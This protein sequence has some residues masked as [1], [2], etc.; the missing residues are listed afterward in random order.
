MLFHSSNII[1]TG[2]L[3][4]AIVFTG[5]CNIVY[6]FKTKFTRDIIVQEKY[7]RIE[8]GRHVY[9][10][11][12]AKNNHYCVRRSLL[13]WSLYPAENWQFLKQGKIYKITGY[14]I[15]CGILNIYPNIVSV[16]KETIEFFC[17]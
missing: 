11:V 15:R 17:D 10:V 14:G 1:N 7:Q 12:D 16:S 4:G 8:E 9:M 2:L 3:V 6:V 13:F 5:A